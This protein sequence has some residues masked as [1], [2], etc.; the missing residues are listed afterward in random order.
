MDG[1]LTAKVALP[2]L[3]LLCA[4]ALPTGKAMADEEYL[5]D[6]VQVSKNELPMLKGNCPIG[7]G[8]WGK[9][10]PQNAQGLFWIQCGILTKPMSLTGAKRIYQKISTDVWMKQEGREYRCLIGPYEDFATANQEKIKVRQLTAYKDAF[11]REVVEKGKTEPAK[12]Q[13][14][15]SSKPMPKAALVAAPVTPQKVTAKKP[16][17]VAANKS[18]KNKPVASKQAE[19]EKLAKPAKMVSGDIEIRRQSKLGIH[20]YV[21]PYVLEDN[22]SFY[23][24]YDRAWNRM[25]YQSAQALCHKLDMRLAKNEEWQAILDSGELVKNK[26][27]IHLP[28]W[29]DS[30]QGFFTNGKV[31]Q[32]KGSSL[33]NVL[34]IEP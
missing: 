6:A 30:N 20:T 14:S 25:N 3:A 27:P 19:P 4:L 7:N 26:W 1:K 21:V 29:G 11:V 28:Y 34:C 10:K 18:V 23:M 17:A 31:T 15:A 24:E 9:K 32:L 8:V 16:D 12:P 33:L 13:T 22:N 5:C 2:I